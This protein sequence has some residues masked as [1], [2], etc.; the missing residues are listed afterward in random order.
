MILNQIQHGRQHPT[1]LKQ[2]A[3]YSVL[4]TIAVKATFIKKV[5]DQSGS[6]ALYKTDA[7]LVSS[8][9][10]RNAVIGRHAPIQSLPFHDHKKMLS[11]VTCYVKMLLQEI[12]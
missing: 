6:A 11:I 4:G 12:D 9:T 7:D 5:L 1:S 3:S 2:W 8:I 10:D